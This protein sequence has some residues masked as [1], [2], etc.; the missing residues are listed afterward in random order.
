MIVDEVMLK[1]KPNQLTKVILKILENS[2]LL[3]T[4]VVGFFSILNAYQTNLPEF[5]MLTKLTTHL[6]LLLFLSLEVM[7]RAIQPTYDS[8]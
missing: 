1:I 3:K 6:L 4:P 5:P 8:V 7:A 2:S